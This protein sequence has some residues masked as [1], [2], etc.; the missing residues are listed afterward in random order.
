MTQLIV[1]YLSSA[2]IIVVAS[3]IAKRTGKLGAL[4]AALPLVTIMI[5]TWLHIEH[6]GNQKIGTYAYYTFWY[7]LP[8][9][10]MFLL[11]AWLMARDVNFWLALLI[12]AA[13]TTICF[14][15]TAIVMKRFGINLMP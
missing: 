14:I 7:V 8:T 9:L 12:C 6:Q 1:K 13:L 11:M 2:L 5:M 15:L 4:I 10:P 3:E